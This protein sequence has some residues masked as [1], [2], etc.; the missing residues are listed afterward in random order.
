MMSIEKL[1]E[2]IKTSM[3][4]G[5]KDNTV[6]LRGILALAQDIAKNDKNREL[7]DN[8][9]ITACTKSKK[10]ALE[11]IDTYKNLE[12]DVAQ[13]NYLR[14]VR[15]EKL[16]NNYLPTQ[17]TEA[18]LSEAVDSAIKKL[19]ATNMKDMGKV[20]GYLT[21]NYGKGTYDGAMASKIVRTKLN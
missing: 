5:E 10:E 18:D 17:M 20:M 19:S 6:T 8:D 7:T 21:S 16:A 9:V 11:G 12:G 13:A 3:K 15:L 4:S 1:K 2:D 14:N